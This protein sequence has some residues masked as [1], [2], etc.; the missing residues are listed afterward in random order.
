MRVYVGACE[1]RCMWVHV[2]RCMRVWVRVW[3][4]ECMGACLCVGGF[5]CI[6]TCVLLVWLCV[7]ACV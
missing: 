2:C 5:M 6:C 7:G 4:H 1:C 3:V